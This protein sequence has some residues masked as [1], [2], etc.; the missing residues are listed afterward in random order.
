MP[1][2]RGHTAFTANR[3]TAG[4]AITQRQD[5]DLERVLSD[6]NDRV[7]RLEEL[8]EERDGGRVLARVAF[9]IDPNPGDFVPVVEF[10]AS[11]RRSTLSSTVLIVELDPPIPSQSIPGNATAETYEVYGSSSR[12]GYTVIPKIRS[13]TEFQ[14]VLVNTL[15]ARVAFDAQTGFYSFVV[16]GSTPG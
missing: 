11:I 16:I 5:T 6:L 1:Q 12:D 3:V 10:N 13:D 15:N 4:S 14:I 2:R 8:A 9:D 7:T